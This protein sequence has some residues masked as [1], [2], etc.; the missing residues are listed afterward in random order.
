MDTL[1]LIFLFL[2][3]GGDKKICITKSGPDSNEVCKFPFRYDGNTYYS[4]TTAGNTFDQRDPWCSTKVDSTGKHVGGQ[5][6]WGW[7]RH[8]CGV[9]LKTPFD[10][11]GESKESTI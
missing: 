9:P 2:G 3:G 4:C 10:R 5:G 6:K 1:H 11:N 7:C 8:S